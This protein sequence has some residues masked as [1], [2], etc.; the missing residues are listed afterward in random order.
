MFRLVLSFIEDRSWLE[1]LASMINGSHF[2]RKYIVTNSHINLG[3]EVFISCSVCI[4]V[5]SQLFKRP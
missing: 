5:M 1:R 3:T 4:S 2:M